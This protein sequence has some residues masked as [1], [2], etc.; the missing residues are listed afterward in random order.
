MDFIAALTQVFNQKLPGWDAHRHLCPPFRDE[1]LE[2]FRSPQYEASVGII[3]TIMHNKLSVLFIERTNDGGPH[4]GQIAFPGGKID[5]ADKTPLHA[6]LREVNEEIGL[7]KHSLHFIRQLSS[8]YIPVSQFLVYP[9]V[10]FCQNL[11]ELAVNKEEIN[12][13]IIVPI[14]AFYRKE[15]LTFTN[16]LFK[17]KSYAVPCFKVNETIIWGATAMIWN[18]CLTLLKPLF[19][20]E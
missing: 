8:L 9:F 12:Q 13:T 14:D 17:N 3:L 20:H 5:Y 7:Q 1:Q 10:F 18:E 4:S 11:P 19:Q 6:A 2:L 15:V 16:F